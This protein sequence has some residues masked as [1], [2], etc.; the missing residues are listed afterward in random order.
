MSGE[1]GRTRKS[2]L[3]LHRL[4]G[5]TGELQLCF[6]RALKRAH[7]TMY[8]FL[9]EVIREQVPFNTKDQAATI[10]C[11][12]LIFKSVTKREKLKNNHFKD[13]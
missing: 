6:M 2:S 3:F 11:I 10:K 9:K 8:A 4:G 13:I 7:S 5:N 12:S 1:Q